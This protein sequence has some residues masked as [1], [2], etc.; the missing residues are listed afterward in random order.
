MLVNV[1]TLTKHVFEIDVPDYNKCTIENL[2]N[3]IKTEFNVE[4]NFVLIYG[5]KKC[6]N[7]KTLDNYNVSK[8]SLYI[9]KCNK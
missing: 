3:Q 2:I 8:D 7:S 6:D 4:D 5:G 9:V 1:K